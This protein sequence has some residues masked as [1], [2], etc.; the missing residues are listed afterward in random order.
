MGRH[1]FAI[2]LVH[3]PLIT[4]L[5]PKGLERGPARLA[6]GLLA[7]TVLTLL[8][9]LL[10]ERAV[11]LVEGILRRWWRERGAVVAL[12]RVAGVLVALAT[13]L[14][15]AELISRALDPR[16]LPGSGWGERPALAADSALGWRLKPSQTT[17]L[18][19]ESYDYV[20]TSN[21][22]GF[23]GGDLPA[24]RPPGSLRVLVTGD[25]FSS[26]EGVDTEASWPALLEARLAERLPGRL[27]QV[28]NAAVTGYGPNQY[29]AVVRTLGPVLR[30]DLIIVEFFINDFEDVMRSDSSFRASIGFDAPRPGRPG[31]VLRLENLS[32]QWR[33][34]VLHPL[35]ERLD[36]TPRPYGYTL[37]GF[38]WLERGA[39]S[40][41]ASSRLE[42]RLAEIRDTAAALG[43]PV[44]AVLV[45]AAAQVC[46]PPALELAP[47]NVSLEDTLRFDPRGPATAL[48]AITDRLGI[49][50]LE[51]E[52]ALRGGECPYQRRN[53]H[54]TEAGHVRVAG[55]L[56]D[57]L[58]AWIRER[59]A[60]GGTPANPTAG[61]DPGGSP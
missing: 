15:G 21:A 27:I 46:D 45:P 32:S 43:A 44:L 60:P 9:S 49:P 6:I 41:E 19:W 34:D 57:T 3:H 47:R 1:S 28:A 56:A 22:L 37:A 11:N 59:E 33:H 55:Y 39:V 4:R 29:A 48:R 40:E 18:R 17:R 2:F 13:L 58:S 52:P 5:I 10:L 35:R 20:V 31:S 8:L 24:S 23:P 25:A 38:R 14:I 50:L 42:A 30:P 53:M 12:A 7:A 26:A 16:E 36:G 51:L 61:P 54:W